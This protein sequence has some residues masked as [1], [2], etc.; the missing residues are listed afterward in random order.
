[1]EHD[2]YPAAYLAEILHSATTI[3]VL[4]ASV[5]KRRPSHWIAGFLLGKG[6]RVFP[7][8]PKYAGQNILGQPVYARLIDI[9]VNIDIVD[10]FRRADQ[11]GEVVDEIL[12]LPELPKVIWG[13][14]GVRDDEAA[15][16]AEAAGVRIVMD[17][18]LVSE[19][20]LVHELQHTP[21]PRSAA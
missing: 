8:N 3:V 14:L 13:Q 11:F 7:V 20:P 21:R 9:P 5:D 16:R 19:Y 18:A 6:Y 12:K 17:R 1:M 15:S 4:G 2:F 10:V